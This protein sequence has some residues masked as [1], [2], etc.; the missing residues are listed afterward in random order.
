MG[1]MFSGRL[2]D[3]TDDETPTQAEECNLAAFPKFVTKCVQEDIGAV[4]AS[5]RDLGE[6]IRS[7]YN[8]TVFIRSEDHETDKEDQNEPRHGNREEGW[9][10]SLL[11]TSTTTKKSVE[12][13]DNVSSRMGPCVLVS[14]QF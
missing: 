1:S 4:Q 9:A 2:V 10:R 3:A 8:R 12:E 5:A 7:E 6:D 11:G 13:S 14:L